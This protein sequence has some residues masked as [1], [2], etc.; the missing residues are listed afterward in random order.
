MGTVD[1]FLLEVDHSLGALYTQSECRQIGYRLLED[2]LGLSLS[3]ILLRGKD[4]E[5]AGD[6]LNALRER[7]QKL[8][9][10]MPLQYVLGHA[11]FYGL[12][13]EVAP[14]VLIPRPE[15]EELTELLLGRMAS[16][17]KASVRILDLGTGSG[18]IPIALAHHSTSVA[19][20]DALELSPEAL[21]I[22]GRNVARHGYSQAI[23]LIAGDMLTWRPRGE[24]K[25]G[26]YQL[27]V[28]N[29][30]Y[31]H[32]GEAEAMTASVLV[33]EPEMA[34]FAPA[35]RPTLYY[36]AVAEIALVG[37]APGAEVWAEINPLYARQTLEVMSA[38]LASRLRG[39]RLVVDMSG[40]E[41][42]VHLELS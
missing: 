22:S 18:C 4:I 13:L 17:P 11:D 30:P 5:I 37:G 12:S 6:K 35:D 7:L 24:G 42:F 1:Q 14:G 16:Y 27:I 28:S 21:A 20:I 23:S 3:D 38:I 8:S 15:T 36:E 29:P 2:A 32:P 9:E 25:A 31:I 19:H 26:G 41:R 39:G 33:H 34:L 40:K 10:G